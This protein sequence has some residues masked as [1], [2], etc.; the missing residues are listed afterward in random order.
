MWVC[1]ALFNM[2][3]VKMIQI[4]LYPVMPCLFIKH[5]IHEMKCKQIT[6]LNMKNAFKYSDV[7][8]LL[9]SLLHWFHIKEGGA[10]KPRPSLMTNGSVKAC[11]GQIKLFQKILFG[12][13]LLKRTPDKLCFGLISFEIIIFDFTSCVYILI[14]LWVFAAI[15]GCQMF[16]LVVILG[17]L[18][19]I[20]E[21]K[22]LQ[23]AYLIRSVW[24]FSL[25]KP[26]LIGQPAQSVGIGC[27]LN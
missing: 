25:C 24:R 1:A 26:L 8:L 23:M 22:P 5:F 7:M 10:T 9:A 15:H 17:I 6:V 3:S 27:L 2:M 11:T 14:W 20:Y 19:V 16:I 21:S 4:Q 18:C 13:K 12:F